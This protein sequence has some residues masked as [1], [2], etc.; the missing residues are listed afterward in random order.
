VKNRLA[1]LVSG[2]LMLVSTAAAAQ[3]GFIPTRSPYLDLEQSQEFTIIV[4][5]YHGHRDPA[6]VAPG[7]GFLIGAHYEWRAGGPAHITGEITRSSSDSRI[8]NPL[9]GGTG[10]DLGNLSRP[11]YSA[12]VGLGLSLTGA[13]SWHHIVPELSSGLG[14]ISDFRS[15]PDTGGFKFGTRFAINWGGGIR[16]VPGGKWAVRGDITNK[17]Y[18]ISY[19]ETFFVAPTGAPAVVPSTQARSFWMNNPAFTLGLSRLF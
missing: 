5:Q 8:I 3:V 6:D 14:F 1:P 15:Q 2:M 9:V 4:G 17:L 18:T 12:N 19:P 11:L 7:G 16:W 13:K 10:R